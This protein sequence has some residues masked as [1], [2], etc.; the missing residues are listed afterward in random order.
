MNQDPAAERRIPAPP[1]ALVWL[2]LVV[3]VVTLGMA[4]VG[5]WRTGIG[6]DETYHVE[7]MDNYL[8]DGWYVLDRDL[9]GA[10]PTAPGRTTYVYGPVTMI[11]LHAWSTVWGVDDS[12]SVA[13][14]T[15]A[16]AVRHLGVLL[17]GLIGM[18]AAA[19][20]AR[21][22]L[23]AGW[24]VV[25]AG[26]LGAVP[27]WTGHLMFN[28][29]DV[30]VATGCTLL[31]LGLVGMAGARRTDRWHSR[32][33]RIA[34]LA[35]GCTLALGTR[36]G[37]WTL[38]A[39]GLCTVGF[40][41]LLGRRGPTASRTS[42]IGLI[43]AVTGLAVAAGLLLAAYPKAFS[44]P[45]R[46]LRRSAESSS[47][48][49]DGASGDRWYLFD[50][51]STDMP[52]VLVALWLLGSA[53]GVAWI[54]RSVL[55]P[56]STRVRAVQVALVGV[57]AFTLPVVAV[58]MKSDLYNGLRQM[59]FVAPACAV[60]ATVGL[61]WALARRSGFPRFAIVTSVAVLGLVL[62]VAAQALL[63]PYNYTYANAVTD[64]LGKDVNTDYWR[65]SVREL[66]PDVP[67]D[68]QVVCTPFTLPDG[69]AT[70]ESSDG[71]VDCR[72]TPIGPLATPWKHRGR[73]VVYDIPDAEFYAINAGT[74]AVA[75]NCTE[76]HRV[77]RWRHGRDVLMSRVSRCRLLPPVLRNAEV[78]MDAT[79]ETWQ[80]A[81][82]GWQPG[83]LRGGLASDGAA[84]SIA[85]QLPDRCAAG[86]ALV[87]GAELTGDTSVLTA[88][89]RVLRMERLTERR[90]RID[91]PADVVAGS[92]ADGLWLTFSRSTDAP[93]AMTFRS[94]RLLTS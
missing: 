84:A 36:P 66:E 18:A 12:G 68:G 83:V 82:R 14:T 75:P 20:T 30:P 58:L 59:L 28:L 78:R 80:Y 15:S 16:Y 92:S 88:Q 43:E 46:T 93:L 7:R 2:S 76:V 50:H 35:L 21:R 72:I 87:L 3:L 81:V 51:V 5:A 41:V 94:L 25:A 6:W 37:T 10:G 91:L 70:R 1:R 23:G 89:G 60:L 54:V 63:F 73:P 53:V 65:T 56:G 32:L 49:R 9:N 19:A 33:G 57:Q 67:G 38:V 74:K 22:L 45:F 64:A 39:A 42:A 11:L 31:T 34:V 26:V 8:S 90:A 13:T 52:L 69:T 85:F 79:R 4:L 71:T 40:L 17:I 27:L 55:R 48:F 86:C 24:G 29:K 62:P 77:T 61:A 47:Q 44:T